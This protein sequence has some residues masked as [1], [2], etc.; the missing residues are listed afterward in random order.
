MFHLQ[1]LDLPQESLFMVQTDPMRGH[2][3]VK[4]AEFTNQRLLALAF[5][6]GAD[7][8]HNDSDGRAN[9]MPL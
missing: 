3:H 4:E 7:D 1:R 8:F 2:V 6:P 5:T 9:L